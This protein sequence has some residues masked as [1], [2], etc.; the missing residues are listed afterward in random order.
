[1]NGV[2]TDLPEAAPDPTA[3]PSIFSAL[4]KQLGLKLTPG[5][6]PLDVIIVE[7]AEKPTAN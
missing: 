5:K 3:S 4:E 6:A 2:A 1:L 7:H